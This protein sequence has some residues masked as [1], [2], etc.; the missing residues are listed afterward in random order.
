MA[1]VT[2]HGLLEKELS[3]RPACYSQKQGEG[4]VPT[5]P[6]QSESPLALGESKGLE[7]PF[8]APP[9]PSSPLSQGGGAAADVMGE[10]LR[11]TETQS[12]SQ[13]RN[14]RA[15]PCFCLVSCPQAF[16]LVVR[17]QARVSP[18][19]LPAWIDQ[20]GGTCPVSPTEGK[21]GKRELY[22]GS[23]EV[24]EGPSPKRSL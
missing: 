15:G 24:T 20:S 23:V 7:G 3:T 8:L 14:Q 2:G 18:A 4:C 22:F 9:L 16:T 17:P 1:D 13:C 11:P 6:P 10:S 12:W 5:S 21:A 19:S